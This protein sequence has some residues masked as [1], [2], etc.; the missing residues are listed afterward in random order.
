MQSRASRRQG[1]EYIR[2]RA[3]KPTTA[4]EK[5]ADQRTG[6]SGTVPVGAGVGE[7]AATISEA[8]ASI[9]TSTISA[10]RA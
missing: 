8:T 6:S 5:P 7:I 1:G 2:C 4:S 9:A 10:R 3:N